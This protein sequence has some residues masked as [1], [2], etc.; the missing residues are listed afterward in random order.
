M[1]TKN[2]MLRMKTNPR[3][4]ERRRRRSSLGTRY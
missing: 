1:T 4:R 2:Q 3:R